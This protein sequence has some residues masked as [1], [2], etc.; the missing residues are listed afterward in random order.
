MFSTLGS[1]IEILETNSQTL[2]SY[3]Q[4]IET[5]SQTLESIAQ[6]VIAKIKFALKI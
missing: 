5:S 1:S 2:E 6:K 3:I 4:T